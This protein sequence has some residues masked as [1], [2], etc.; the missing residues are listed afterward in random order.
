MERILSVFVILFSV[1]SL[2][3]SK[4]NLIDDH[5]HVQE[6]HPEVSAYEQAS[7]L[8]PVYVKVIK[9]LNDMERLRDNLRITLG[10]K[11]I[12]KNLI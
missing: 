1:F 6:N 2:I 9:D 4:S 10:S 7:F 3:L 11:Y 8:Y 5:D 12:I